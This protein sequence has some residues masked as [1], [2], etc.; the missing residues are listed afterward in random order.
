MTTFNQR[1][2]PTEENGRASRQQATAWAEEKLISFDFTRKLHGLFLRDY[3]YLLMATTT[4][5]FWH[6][7]IIYVEDSLC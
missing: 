3:N 5:R 4:P 2:N 7:N 1:W 6:I